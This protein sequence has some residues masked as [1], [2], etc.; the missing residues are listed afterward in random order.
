MSRAHGFEE[1]FGLL[2]PQSPPSLLA[3]APDSVL[4]VYSSIEAIIIQHL[5][6]LHEN[7]WTGELEQCIE[8]SSISDPLRRIIFQPL[9]HRVLRSPDKTPAAAAG[10]ALAETRVLA[11]VSPAL[12]TAEASAM[13]L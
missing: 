9:P 7:P 11:V 13:V 2:L 10:A 5:Y 8:I 6:C 3:H 12:V 4:R 1:Y